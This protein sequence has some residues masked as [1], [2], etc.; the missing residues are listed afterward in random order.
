[1]KMD[2]LFRKTAILYI[3]Q[4]SSILGNSTIEQSTPLFKFSLLQI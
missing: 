4:E 1:M 2:Y 3:A